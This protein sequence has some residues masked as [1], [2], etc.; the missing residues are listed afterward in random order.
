MK[1]YVNDGCIGCGL[2]AATCPNVFSMADEDIAKA[3]DSDISAEDIES[4]AEAKENCPVGAIEESNR[5]DT[6]CNDCTKT[7]S[8]EKKPDYIRL[9][10]L[11]IG[12]LIGLART[13]DGN[14]QP[15]EE[16]YK[17][18]IKGL[19]YSVANVPF[20]ETDIKKLI[21]EI[22]AEK[23][24]LVPR[25]SECASPCGRNNDYDMTKLQ[26]A[27]PNI[28]SLKVL[29]LFGIRGLA[30]L[31]YN[32]GINGISIRVAD[33]LFAKALFA[34]GEDWGT[35]G[36]LPI[37]SEFAEVSSACVKAIEIANA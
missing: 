29:L 14:T 5:D 22:H 18:L 20:D 11:L 1:Y 36:L 31:V 23:H 17:L 33:E 4:A 15:T 10:K 19:Y 2:C 26:D 32:A 25:C 7:E 30:T 13:T 35:D 12:A 6:Y 9:Q 37:I 34:I 27:D 28:R 24:R 21:D 3:I 8:C 16:T